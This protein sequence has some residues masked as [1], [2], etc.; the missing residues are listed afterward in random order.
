MHEIRRE[1]TDEI[2]KEITKVAKSILNV[3]SEN[4]EKKHVSNNVGNVGVKKHRSKKSVQISSL[5]YVGWNHRKAVIERF[6]LMK[7]CIF[8][9][10]CKIQQRNENYYV[11]D[12][13]NSRY[14]RS[15]L[16]TIL[17][18][19]RNQCPLTKLQKTSGL[20]SML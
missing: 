6:K 7:R 10:E 1:T 9:E 13:E 11:Y 16:G 14:V 12:Y 2:K 4:V 3:V 18:S 5:K 8:R 17:V 20:D 19:K 15:C